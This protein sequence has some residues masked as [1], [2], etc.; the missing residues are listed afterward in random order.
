MRSI[1]HPPGSSRVQQRD[2]T[3]RELV[4]AG[5]RMVAERGFAA[6]TTAAIAQASG[7]AHGTV[8]VHFRSREAMVAELVEEL[9][10][11]MSQRLVALPDN[12]ATL[13]DVLDAHLAALRDHEVLYAR[14]LCE[15]STLP[16][17]ARARV[18][19]LQSGVAW[20]LREAHAREVLANTARAMAP[21]ALANIWIALT[22]HYLMHRDLFA[23]G[24]SVIAT[25]GA[26]L[27]AQL[28]EIVQ[29]PPGLLAHLEHH[30]D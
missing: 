4:Q 7:K 13:A 10:R 20:R 14:L 30:H 15:A 2:A 27:K 16:P 3:R 29:P 22:N 11:T 25:H 17:A 19:A 6:T 26:E 5:L 9:G 18:F 21:V 8:F 12:T 24:A 28:L 1:T 23:P